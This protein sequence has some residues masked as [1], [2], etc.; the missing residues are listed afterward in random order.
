MLNRASAYN[1]TPIKYCLS[2]RWPTVGAG[3]L[4]H[5][6]RAHKMTLDKSWKELKEEWLERAV[7]ERKERA[8][9]AERKKRNAEGRPRS[10]PGSKLKIHHGLIA[11][12]S[13][14]QRVSSV[15]HFLDNAGDKLMFSRA[16]PPPPS[17]SAPLP[18]NKA[19]LRAAPK[20]TAKI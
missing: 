8:E 13:A 6:A 11:A 15:G 3:S 5:V 17:Q 2:N 12:G 4:L 18:A 10:L 1:P 16:A 14:T 19:P 20:P 9:E 7:K